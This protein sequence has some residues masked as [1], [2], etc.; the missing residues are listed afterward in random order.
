MFIIM[1]FFLF[2]LITVV[3][4]TWLMVK[5][6]DCRSYLFQFIILLYLKLTVNFIKTV[7]LFFIHHLSFVLNILII[8][9]AYDVNF[10]PIIFSISSFFISLLKESEQLLLI[11]Y[12][13]TGIGLYYIRTL[14]KETS[15]FI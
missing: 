2:F 4:F 5:F 15:V 10:S 12:N 9:F 7:L 11:L 8:V 1:F 3:S 14:H 13:G 6:K